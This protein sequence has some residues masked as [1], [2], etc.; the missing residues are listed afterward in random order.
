[1]SIPSIP[2][3]TNQNPNEQL[4]QS[5][6]EVIVKAFDDHDQ[7]KTHQNIIGLIENKI[8]NSLPWR[9]K[10]LKNENGICQ[11]EI[12]QTLNYKCI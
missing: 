9:N 11:D 1:M 6:F 7:E 8:N 3:L 5:G 4:I 10:E 12:Q 2:A